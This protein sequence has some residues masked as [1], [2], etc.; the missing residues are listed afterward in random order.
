MEE[1]Q[2]FDHPIRVVGRY[3]VHG[4]LAA[5]GM[6]TVH[7]GRLLGPAGFTR[8]VAI[9]RLH[10]QFAKDPEFVAMFLDEAR[11]AARIQHPN[12]VATVDVV[13]MK[14]ELFL[15]MDYIRGESFSRLL[16][17]S[18]KKGIE[19]PLPILTSIVAGML[20]G[21]HA[22]HEAKDE[23]GR[24]LA[25]V[26]RDVS[27]QNVLV[28]IDG[29]PRVLD[30]G[31]AKAAARVQ[32]T[33][34]GQMKGKLAYMAPEQLQSRPVDRR[35]DVFA[36]GIVL[37]EA[38]TGRRLFDAE[39]ATEVLRMI[40]SEDIPPPSA[41]IPSIP[42]NLDDVVMKALARDPDE[43][44]QTARQF[45]IALEDVV[46]LASPRE[47][48]EWVEKVAGDTLQH[49]ELAVAEIE[50]ISQ[51]SDVSDAS[52]QFMKTLEDVDSASEWDEA[53]TNVYDTSAPGKLRADDSDEN[54]RVHVPRPSSLIP[55]ARPGPA[56]DATVPGGF[57]KPPPL[58][59]SYGV[60]PEPPLE[61]PSAPPRP[62]ARRSMPPPKPAWAKRQSSTPPPLPAGKPSAPP[63][64]PPREPS[65]VA[66]AAVE[67]VPPASA[68]PSGPPPDQIFDDE[69][70]TTTVFDK[71]AQSGDAT[72]LLL[73]P[74]KIGG[75][76]VPAA[77]PSPAI[78]EENETTR[79]FEP[80]RHIPD[81]HEPT[82]VV[83]SQ[84]F[85]AAEPPPA[86]TPAGYR[87]KQDTLRPEKRPPVLVSALQVG[88]EEHTLPAKGRPTPKARA[89]LVAWFWA[90][91]KQRGIR[92]G[93][94]AAA[95]VFLAVFALASAL[96]RRGGGLVP[97]VYRESKRVRVEVPEVAPVAEREPP[98]VAEV[99]PEPP[100][101]A[102]PN[103]A[104]APPSAAMTPPPSS[105]A[106]APAPPAASTEPAPA[107]TIPDA[108]AEPA[109]PKKK[110]KRAVSLPPAVD[111]VAPAGSTPS[112]S[113]TKPTASPPTPA[114]APAPA[115][116]PPSPPDEDLE[117][118]Y[119]NPYSAAGK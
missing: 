105:A 92:I 21:L 94:V 69:N 9:K 74:D 20:H 22:A 71:D 68:K 12:V 73:G 15:V 87:A 7:F 13:A 49:R 63:A 19:V 48:G 8:T 101:S 42:R 85:A 81:E 54:T 28:G 4:K 11:L 108:Q 89:P 39:E 35:T 59:E 117:N 76:A 66:A 83:R 103:A 24:P 106:L 37:W 30:F 58:P 17:T 27:P 36:A 91:P 2:N 50:A 65:P 25:V 45:A 86:T 99:V 32:V 56:F 70:E 79:V 61:K 1:S 80:R 93:A 107:P 40:V 82:I 18:R 95:L 16:R 33:R 3:A 14:E 6:A 57:D 84:P 104:E 111:G 53:P 67:G 77:P 23:H 88:A 100:V 114:P 46:H 98:K 52:R 97:A 41:V 51:V 60:E 119:A 62:T 38:L 112:P 26:H 90:D 10:P 116:A 115:P 96:G 29:V 118:P 5:G 110:K 34:D 78:V 44:Y 55:S 109:K 31:V 113:D 43:R 72:R 102:V 64:E 47:I 75:G